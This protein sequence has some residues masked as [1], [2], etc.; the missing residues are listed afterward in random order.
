MVSVSAKFTALASTRISTWPGPG[1][2]AG[3]SSTVS[4]DGGPKARHNTAFTFAPSRSGDARHAGR[5]RSAWQARRPYALPAREGWV[6]LSPT[7]KEAAADR[8]FRTGG[9]GRERHGLRL[10]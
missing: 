3:T 9:P 2:G 7:G 6:T 4:P 10:F 5:R 8:L 1:S